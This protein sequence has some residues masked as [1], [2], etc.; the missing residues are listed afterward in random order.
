MKHQFSEADLRRRI[1]NAK[2]RALYWSG[3]PSFAQN[4]HNPNQARR[5]HSE[6]YELAMCDIKSLS[7]LLEDITGETVPRYDPKADFQ[8]RYHALMN[9]VTT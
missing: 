9:K 4:R 7:S 5:H 2:T 3:N 8:R 6:M 1:K